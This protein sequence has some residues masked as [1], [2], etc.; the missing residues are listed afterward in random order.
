M[1]ETNL[2]SLYWFKLGLFLINLANYSSAV[3][4]NE[5]NRRFWALTTAISCLTKPG[6]CD[7]LVFV[8]L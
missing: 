5:K 2:K 6:K 8:G 1:Q 7:K 4:A 3:V